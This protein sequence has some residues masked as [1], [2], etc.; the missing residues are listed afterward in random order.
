MSWRARLEEEKKMESVG[1]SKVTRLTPKPELL[2][3]LSD[4]QRLLQMKSVES[5]RYVKARIAVIVHSYLLSLNQLNLKELY[6]L[7]AKLYNFTVKT[8]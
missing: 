4:Y 3:R 8:T 2:I 1:K 5:L 6:N 7:S